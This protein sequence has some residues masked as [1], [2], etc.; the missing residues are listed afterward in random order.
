MRLWELLKL[1]LEAA[2]RTP[3]R[4]ALTAIGVAIATGA[5]V[6]MVGFASGLQ[7]QAERPFE[8]L[9]LASR[10]EVSP[11]GRDRDAPEFG[12]LAAPAPLDDEAIEGFRKIPG[13]ALAYPQIVLP[14]VQVARDGKSARVFASGLPRDA[15]ALPF[16]KER[17]LTGSFFSM[18]EKEEVLLDA[19]GIEDLGFETPEA[20]LGATVTLRPPRGEPFDATIVGVFKPLPLAFGSEARWAALPQE[21]ARGLLPRRE[22]FLSFVPGSG[23]RGEGW[24]SAIVRTD[25]P[26]DVPDVEKA[27]EAAGFRARSMVTDMERL[28]T[29]FFVIHVLLGAVGGVALV[30][31]GLGI[32][33][34]LLMAVLERTKEI[35]AYKAL[36]AS[37][38]D[39]R[40]LFLAEAAIVGLLGG[41]AG[42]ALGRAV[43]WGIG[44]GVSVYARSR[45]VAQEIEL[46]AF[47]EWLVL[48]ALAFAVAASLLSGVYPA[49]RAAKVDPIRALRGE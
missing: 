4:I 40:V 7:D 38:G 34:T 31:A 20:A 12:P 49:S 42:L 17:L 45:G 23:P 47:P 2:R 41:V 30:V 8:E 14:G 5:L 15:G 11:K 43:A 3:L 36:G 29:F 21:K 33:N 18:E 44:A 26:L 35:G 9:D 37:D 24:P 1:A 28:R 48:G 27:I 22:E 46:F 13:V 25:R 39:I 16:A 10:I 19:A 6:S 32:A